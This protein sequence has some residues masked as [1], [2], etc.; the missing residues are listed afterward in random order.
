MKILKNKKRFLIIFSLVSFLFFSVFILINFYSLNIENAEKHL[1]NSNLSIFN[2]GCIIKTLGRN[3]ET[4]SA[5]ISFYEPNGTLCGRYERA[6]QGWELNIECIVLNLKNGNLVF[7]YRIFS[8]KSKHGT[9]VN[10]IPY[11][12][13]NNYPA[14]YGY[15]FFSKE[16]KK[17][18]QTLFK[19]AALSPYLFLFFSSAKKETIPL[20]NFTPD[21]EYTLTVSAAG[22]ISFKKN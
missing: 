2:M 6:W 4:V 5:E 15:T 14:T 17:A 10:L 12:S 22:R 8:D 16:D 11:Y 18:I 20:R 1:A 19:S 9:G 7:P 13:K 3:A 21:T